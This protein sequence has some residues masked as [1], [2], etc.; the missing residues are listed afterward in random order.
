MYGSVNWLNALDE[1]GKMKKGTELLTLLFVFRGGI[2][3]LAL[4]KV[5]SKKKHKVMVSTRPLAH[6]FVS[7]KFLKLYCEIY[8]ALQEMAFQ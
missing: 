2:V 3:M 7:D 6:W 4:E 8:F 5:K 1:L